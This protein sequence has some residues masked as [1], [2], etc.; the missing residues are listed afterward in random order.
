M[1]RNQLR[2]ASLAFTRALDLART[3][4]GMEVRSATLVNAILLHHYL[5]Q[6]D[7]A[8][9][10]QRLLPLDSISAIERSK[11]HEVRGISFL[12]LQ[13]TEQAEREF[14]KSIRDLPNLNAEAGL[15]TVALLYGDKKAAEHRARQVL[16][17]EPKNILATRVLSELGLTTNQ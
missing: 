1:R 11:L 16:S 7:K 3:E 4:D 12:N 9:E 6:F 15:A 5:G 14:N 8:F 2:E 10:L 13:K 17:Q